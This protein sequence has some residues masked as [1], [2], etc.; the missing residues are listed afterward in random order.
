[1]LR[2]LPGKRPEL[3]LVRFNALEAAETR[4]GWILNRH[5]ELKILDVRPRQGLFLSWPI[6]DTGILPVVTCQVP[7]VLTGKLEDDPVLR[8]QQASF[9]HFI[10]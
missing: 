3:D 10:K 6:E 1:M 8:L 4:R 9:P 7:G 5:V 2:T